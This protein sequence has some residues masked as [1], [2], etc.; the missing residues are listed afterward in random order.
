MR[1]QKV[2]GSDL[3]QPPEL[4]S[5][6]DEAVLVVDGGPASPVHHL[7]QRLIDTYAAQFEQAQK[8][9]L[10]AHKKSVA[11][12]GDVREGPMTSMIFNLLIIYV[13]FNNRCAQAS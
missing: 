12:V 1:A 6:F 9:A 13:Y 7:Q 11:Q 2:E 10:A 4:A 5:A 3:C 8:E